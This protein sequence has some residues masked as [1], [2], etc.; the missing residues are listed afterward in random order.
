MWLHCSCGWSADQVGRPVRWFAVGTVKSFG[1]P[2]SIGIS[3]VSGGSCT[4]C[5]S[6]RHFQYPV[7]AANFFGMADGS[8]QRLKPMGRHWLPCP[9]LEHGTWP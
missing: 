4:L 6:C 1:E 8:R 7:L 3:H 5:Y 9:A 2:H